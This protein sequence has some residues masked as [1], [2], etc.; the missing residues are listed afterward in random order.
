MAFEDAC[1]WLGSS[2]SN[3][4]RVHTCAAG[5]AVQLA[6]LDDEHGPPPSVSRDQLRPAQDAGCAASF[7]GGET[8][9]DSILRAGAE[10]YTIATGAHC[11]G[12]QP[13]YIFVR[14]GCP[15]SVPI[16]IQVRSEEVVHA[17]RCASDG[18]SRH[19]LIRCARPVCQVD[20]QR[21]GSRVIPLRAVAI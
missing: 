5:S 8:G 10:G 13:G 11:K 21:F 3:S 4:Y 9:L 20:Q 17:A 15:A 16:T 2:Q 7:A 18:R 12:A 14:N 19:S 1:T 6:N